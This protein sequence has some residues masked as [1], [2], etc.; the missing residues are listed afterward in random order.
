MNIGLT[1][2][3]DFPVLPGFVVLLRYIF[4]LVI[5]SVVMFLAILCWSA[6]G[7]DVGIG[8]LAVVVYVARSM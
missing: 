1:L 5:I 7:V 4:R 8:C 2:M 3:S 6:E